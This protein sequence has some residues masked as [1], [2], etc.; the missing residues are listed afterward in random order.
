M[1]YGKKKPMYAKEADK[2]KKKAM[3]NPHK[4]SGTWSCSTKGI[5]SY[6]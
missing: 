2:K 5:R 6:K 3:S 1:M 4:D